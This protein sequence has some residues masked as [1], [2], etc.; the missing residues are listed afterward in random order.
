LETTKIFLI[1]YCAALAGVIPPGLINMSVAK[2]CMERGKKSGLWVAVGASV[3][4][5]LQAWIAIQLA[6]YIFYNPIY[7]NMLLRTGVVIFLLMGIYFFIKARQK[8]KEIKIGG[9]DETRSFFKGV[10]MST[11][12]VL[13]IPYFCALG[14]GLNVSG[15]VDYDVVNIWAFIVAAMLGTF[16]TLYAYAVFFVRAVKKTSNIQKY[17]NYFMAW[18]MMLLLVITLLRVL[19]GES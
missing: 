4:V 3:I 14:A 7:R 13:P 15:R 16:T 6:R 5:F 8:K 1:T 19:F 12:N 9:H 18:L 2:T 17:T 10:M 11:L